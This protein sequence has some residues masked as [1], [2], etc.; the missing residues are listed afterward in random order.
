[1][2]LPEIRVARLAG[3]R[4]SPDKPDESVAV[5]VV[6]IQ[7]VTTAQEEISKKVF[8]L[9]RTHLNPKELDI[10]K[11]I[12]FV[13]SVPFTTCGKIDRV[14]LKNLALKKAQNK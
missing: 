7:G 10:I 8:N 12:Y 3:Y 14:A 6:L 5:F 13:D 4:M 11:N 9:L 2:E 1:M